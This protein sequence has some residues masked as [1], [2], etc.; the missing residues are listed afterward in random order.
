MD[1]VERWCRVAVVDGHGAELR[2]CVLE[3]HGAPDLATVDDVARLGLLAVRLGGAVVLADVSPRLRELLELAGLAV[4]MEGQTEVAEEPLGR[5]QGQE[6]AQ[7]G[8]L[9]P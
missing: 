1:G 7:A 8:D 3:G 6:E 9:A 5:H 4:E 2:W